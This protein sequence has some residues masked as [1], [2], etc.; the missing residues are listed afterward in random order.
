VASLRNGQP[1]LPDINGHGHLNGELTLEPMSNRSEL[2]NR[3]LSSTDISR[4]F[5]TLD[6]GPS[7]RNR[8]AAQTAGAAAAQTTASLC[9]WYASECR[10]VLRWQSAETSF[11]GSNFSGM[12][13][14][15]SERF[16]WCLDQ[17]RTRDVQLGK[18]TVDCK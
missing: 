6:P 7:Q 10:D 4:H 3:L 2:H 5:V 17:T 16:L 18:M 9:Q 15:D 13:V 12:G 14:S 1:S 11:A 8:H